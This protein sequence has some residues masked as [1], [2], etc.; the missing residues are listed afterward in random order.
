MQD[1]LGTKAPDDSQIMSDET[2][3][4]RREIA[5]RLP[6][7][8]REEALIELTKHQAKAIGDD[9][10]WERWYEQYHATILR[11]HDQT[12]EMCHP[13]WIRISNLQ[14]AAAYILISAL[15]VPSVRHWW[16]LAPASAWCVITIVEGYSLLQRF[17]NKWSTY[18]D[19]N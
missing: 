9:L 13:E 10:E 15:F 17:F 16:W 4:S 7:R 19:Q 2:F 18:S 1:Q 8:E 6:D 11:P 3:E 14:A 12:I 5:G